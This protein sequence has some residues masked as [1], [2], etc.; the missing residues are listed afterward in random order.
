[1]ALLWD[2]DPKAAERYAVALGAGL[3][4]VDSQSA[5]IR[6]LAADPGEVLIIIGSEID[7][8]AACEVAEI[9]RIEHPAVGIVLLRHRLDVTVLASALRVRRP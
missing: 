6:A 7:L 9:C 3:V 2:V 8:G 4:R 5:V 1:M